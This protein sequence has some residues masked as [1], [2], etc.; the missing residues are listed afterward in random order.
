MIGVAP[1][2]EQSK[3]LGTF[4][5][6]AAM[7]YREFYARS[8]YAPTSCR[9]RSGGSCSTDA[10]L[11]EQI[12]HEN[13]DEATG[14]LVVGLTLSGHTPAHWTAQG[15]WLSIDARR[16]GC[17]GISPMNDDVSFSV[18][19]PHTLLVIS[20][21]DTAVSAACERFTDDCRDI[22]NDGVLR[23]RYDQRCSNAMLQLWD[24]LGEQDAYAEMRVDA[25]TQVLISELLRVVSGR[26][27]E[28]A[29]A[30]KRIDSETV[31]DFVHA[32]IGRAHV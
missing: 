15:K 18:S 7:R 25:L 24:A 21:K 13:V 4:R 22:L 2:I 30:G 12:P 28:L 11:V 32:K 27:P 17:L 29:A 14:D 20:I 26:K 6:H 1:S 19:E 23:Y 10:L 16:P 31:C 8:A 9:M 3:A 5:R